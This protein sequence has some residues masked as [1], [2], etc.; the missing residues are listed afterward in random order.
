VYTALYDLDAFR[1][2]LFAAGGAPVVAVDALT[3]ERARSEDRDLLL[4]AMQWVR[5]LL[6]APSSGKDRL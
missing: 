6:M 1:E 2:E 5:Q 3:L 4:V